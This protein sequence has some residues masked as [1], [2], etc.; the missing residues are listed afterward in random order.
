M[1]RRGNKVKAL[2]AIKELE[3]LNSH[4][5]EKQGKSVVWSFCVEEDGV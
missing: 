4:Y 2:T 1:E 3:G 5:A